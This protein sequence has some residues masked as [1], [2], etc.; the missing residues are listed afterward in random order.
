MSSPHSLVSIIQELKTALVWLDETSPT[1]VPMNPQHEFLAYTQHLYAQQTRNR[2]TPIEHDQYAT[3]PT[4][5]SVEKSNNGRCT[6]ISGP[7]GRDCRDDCIIGFT[8]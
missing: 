6:Q 5:E 8:V 1:M 2:H 3:Q 4:T 7:G